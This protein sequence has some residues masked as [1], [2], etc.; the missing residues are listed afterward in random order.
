ML[1]SEARS[2]RSQVQRWGRLARA[3][4][5]DRNLSG[6]EHRGPDAAAAAG[7]L[8]G[9]RQDFDP[10]PIRLTVGRGNVHSA[11]REIGAVCSI[12]MQ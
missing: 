11:G 5:E 4:T 12:L 2:P 1:E 7:V 3:A 6:G 8:S 9:P 10:G